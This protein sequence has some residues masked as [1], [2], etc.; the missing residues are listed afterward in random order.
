MKTEDKQ[1][2]TSRVD[3][4]RGWDHYKSRKTQEQLQ[5]SEKIFRFAVYSLTTIGFTFQTFVV[6]SEYFKYPTVTSVTVVQALPVTNFPQI[7]ICASW[8]CYLRYKHQVELFTEHINPPKGTYPW[9]SP[10]ITSASI[11]RNARSTLSTS[12]P[13]N[14]V[15]ADELFEIK[16]FLQRKSSCFAIR[17]KKPLNL[18][19]DELFRSPVTLNINV[20]FHIE[21]PFTGFRHFFKNPR[22]ISLTYHNYMTAYDSDFDVPSL[23]PLIGKA[24]KNQEGFFTILSYSQKVISL[25]S[26]PYDTNCRDYRKDGLHSQN[27]CK[28]ECIDEWTINNHN[29]IFEDHIVDRE[30]H[31]RRYPKLKPLWFEVKDEDMTADYLF[32]MSAR[33]YDVEK[34]MEATN[35]TKQV[36]IHKMIGDDMKRF[37]KLFPA[38]KERMAMCESLCRHPDCYLEHVVPIRMG[39]EVVQGK[40][41]LSTLMLGIH[42]PKEPVVV[43][44]TKEK[45]ML[46]DFV[47]YVLSCLSF[48]F[49][50]CPLSAAKHKALFGKAKFKSIVQSRLLA[51]ATAANEAERQEVTQPTARGRND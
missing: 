31:I 3:K 42:P 8:E 27:T 39:Y 10:V 13:L 24:K 44:K 1:T 38:L 51:V 26:P 28:R 16:Y 25:Y 12:D 34:E 33:A 46:L 4:K 7:A 47:V 50:F 9:G 41:K 32:N 17:T 49:G 18:S 19:P 45:L 29:L 35:N 48:W 23:A 20:T 5:I 40:K 37:A 11:N 22:H 6:C 21:I 14:P 2:W 43:V 15:S 30:R 36:E